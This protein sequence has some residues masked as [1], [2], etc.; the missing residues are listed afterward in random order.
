M[1]APVFFVGFD[2]VGAEDFAGVEVG[3]GGGGGV[4]EDEGGLVLAVATD[5]EVVEVSGAAEGDFTE[6]VDGVEADTD[7]LAILT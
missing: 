5:A 2:G 7:L 6:S 4:D 1:G 3:D